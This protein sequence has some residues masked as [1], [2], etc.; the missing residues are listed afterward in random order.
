MMGVMAE[1]EGIAGLDTSVAHPARVY[2]YWLGG[3][4]NFAVDREAAE[5]VL[6]A[7]PGLRY[8]V[9]ANRAFL[10]RATRYLAAEAAVRQFLDIGTGIPAA[11]NTHEVAQR[12]APDARVVYVDND[13]I[14][15]LHAQ[16]LLR[17]T[18]EGATAYL[19]ADLRDPGAILDR[20]ASLLDFGQPVAVMLLGVLHL[21]Q[22]SE[23]PWG[24]VARLM[25]AMP[26]GSYLTVSHPAIDIHKSQA[27]AQRVYNE[28][29]ATP[30]TLRTREQVARFFAGLELVDPGLVQVHQW[31]PGPGDSA[32][33]GTVS[34]HGAVARKPGA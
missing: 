28:R 5:R 24:I 10:G 32:P 11:G 17:S 3:T 6:A 15:L 13:P 31:R 19:Q 8:R 16:A 12:V 9:R 34:A 18:P 23:D 2:D 1:A 4:D 21:I 14:V 25:T 7:A 20:A 22:D 30:Q 33:E 29:V 27:N 26:P